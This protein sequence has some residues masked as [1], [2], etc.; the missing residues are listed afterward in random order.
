MK[1]IIGLG[2]PGKD[3]EK[4]R[5]N[6]GFMFV[7]FL[8]S[9]LAA[10]GFVNKFSSLYSETT[11]GREKVV[12]LKPQTFMNDSGKAVAEIA[13]FYKIAP[14]N[15]WVA[16]DDLDLKQGEFKIQKA[17]YPKV[18]NGIN[19]I[20]EKLGSDQFNFIRIGIES[21]EGDL[22]K[23]ISGHDYVLQKTDFDFMPTFEAIQK[24]LGI[25]I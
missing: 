21:R 9:K 4:T 10:G 22:R 6:A 15:I 13:K 18:H 14:E 12:L 23:L 11:L 7:D 17:K 16:F 5:H 20:I 24:Q 1:L 2:N 3:Y 19:D 8:A 25:M